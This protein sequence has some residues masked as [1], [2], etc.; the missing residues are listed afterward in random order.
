MLQEVIDKI[1]EKLKN[2]ST[3][4]KVSKDETNNE[5]LVDSDLQVINFDKFSK[6]Y[7]KKF[8]LPV[9]PKSVDSIYIDENDKWY[10]VEFKNGEAKERDLYRKIYDSIIM[11]NQ[12]ELLEWNNCRENMSYIL[13]YNEVEMEKR[14][15]ENGYNNSKSLDKIKRHIRNKA[16]TERKLFKLHKLEGYLLENVRTLNVD[17]FNEE[18]LK[19]WV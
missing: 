8:H 6:V 15:G 16:N 7:S 4:K 12:M 2:I 1:P 11:L 3:I 18:Y 10:F 13:V 5:I 19:K 14:I 9:Q 17:E